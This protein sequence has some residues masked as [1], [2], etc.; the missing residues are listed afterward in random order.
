MRPPSHALHLLVI[1]A[2]KKKNKKQ[3]NVKC[4]LPLTGTVQMFKA[5][6]GGLH[7]WS[8][9]IFAAEQCEHGLW[10][11]IGK[12]TKHQQQSVEKNWTR[13]P[14]PVVKRS[15][16]EN[17]WH[18]CYFVFEFQLTFSPSLHTVP[19]SSPSAPS[20]WHRGAKVCTC[21]SGRFIDTWGIIVVYVMAKVQKKNLHYADTT[22]RQ[23]LYISCV[24]PHR[25]TKWKAEI[26]G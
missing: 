1:K 8:M 9:P 22:R 5:K 16:A 20:L 24:P 7:C 13:T 18:V 15:F 26:W 21:L 3:L 25:V 2:E 19:S 17:R 14:L 23:K 11:K 12:S 6:E 4:A 10:P